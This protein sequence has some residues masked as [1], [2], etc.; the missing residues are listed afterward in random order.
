MFARRLFS[1]S[2]MTAVV[3]LS[4][5]YQSN[6]QAPQG[7]DDVRVY[8]LNHCEPDEI[9]RVIDQVGIG[10]AVAVDSN[11]NSIIL[12]GPV[13]ALG[14]AEKLLKKLDQPER[15]DAADAGVAFI[16]VQ[17]RD[18]EEVLHLV[19]E[20]RRHTGARIGADPANQLIVVNG[21]HSDIEMVRSLVAQFDKPKASLTLSF[22]FIQGSTG[23]MDDDELEY[24]VEELPESLRAVGAALAKNGF[25]HLTLLAPLT[26]NAQENARFS[27]RGFLG[28]GIEEGLEFHVAGKIRRGTQSDSARIEIAAEVVKTLPMLDRRI[29]LFGAETTLLIKLGDYVILAAAPSTLAG[30]E[31]LALVV[32]VD[33][34]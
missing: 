4:T 16:E 28:D 26:A 9:A 27:S 21:S 32:R 12:R 3:I 13:D 7:Q 23:A 18:A 10:V 17:N 33:K 5:A 20:N 25:S 24:A 22:F 31:A 2:V 30:N 34:G 11:S 29:T 1:K 19:R 14:M 6:G 15:S 8:L